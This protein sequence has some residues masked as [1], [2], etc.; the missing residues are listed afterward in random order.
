[1]KKLHRILVLHGPNLQL[2]GHRPAKTYGRLSLAAINRAIA[3]EAHLLGIKVD[4][5]QSNHEGE[6]VDQIG[7]AHHAYG[8]IVINPAA[9][10]HTSV[11][12][13]DAVEAARVPVVEVHLSNVA[14][15]EEFRQISLVTPVCHGQIAGFGVTSYLLG[16][17]AAHA[18]MQRPRT[19]AKRRGS[20]T[21]TRRTA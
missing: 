18:I 6:L 12:I 3:R 16:L 14:A 19:T 21:R 4:A 5:V 2:L 7:A 15:R 8:A 13:R 10:T 20:G 17:R 9:Y 1:V 11:A